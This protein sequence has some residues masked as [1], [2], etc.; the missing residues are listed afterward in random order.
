ML[1]AEIKING[2]TLADVM[3]AIEE[4]ARLISEG[5]TSGGDRNPDASFTINVT[6]ED[7]S[8]EEALYHVAEPSDRPYWGVYRRKRTNRHGLFRLVTTTLSREAAVKQAVGLNQQSPE[9]EYSVQSDTAP[10]PDAYS[11]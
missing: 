2:K 4:A 8:E 7:A 9:Y 3:L 6:G 1:K 5:F 11:P 10:L